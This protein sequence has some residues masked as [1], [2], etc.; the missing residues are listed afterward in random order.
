MNT[1]DISGLKY[2]TNNNSDITVLIGNDNYRNEL[3]EDYII[4]DYITDV[5]KVLHTFARPKMKSRYING[6][7]LIFDGEVIFTVLFLTE[8]ENVKSITLTTPYM[9]T[10]EPKYLSD[11]K[12]TGDSYILSINPIL[13]TVESKLVNPRKLNVKAKL[14]SRVSVSRRENI[15]PTI[16]GLKRPEDELG[17][18]RN[19][20]TVS[21]LHTTQA[22]GDELNISDDIEI[23]A[24][25]PPVKEILF[26]G[27][28]IN[29]NEYRRVGDKIN[30]S[31]EAAVIII[32][33][34]DDEQ[35]Y[36]AV[37]KIPV[38][39]SLDADKLNVECDYF[40]GASIASVKTN[41]ENNNYGE[42]R[43]IEL[44]LTYNIELICVNNED[45]ELTLDAY[46]VDYDCDNIFKDI[47]LYTARHCLNTNFSVNASKE[48]KEIG[49]E[50][51]K[52]IIFTFVTVFINDIK[53]DTVHNKLVVEGNAEISYVVKNENQE[54]S[55]I[56]HNVPIKFE[57]DISVEKEA[58]FEYVYRTAASN[59]RG[60]LDS[61]NIYCD[62][63]VLL[64][65]MLIDYTHENIV[66]KTIFDTAKQVSAE[67]API[68]LYYP[69]PGEKL[70][71]IAK[72]YNTT[73]DAISSANNL[74]SNKIT[75]KNVLII[76]R[77][78]NKAILSKI[79]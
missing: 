16:S 39:D 49:A 25:L 20:K 63:E 57:P 19:A 23:D 40:G 73:C 79:I 1:I 37:K 65:L 69:Q 22:V 59:V 24:S 26:C 47:N 13:E 77:K 31:G 43:I 35:I 17:I 68:V 70:W 46:S 64:N 53:K 41:I 32:Y 75:D 14:C 2:K 45:V 72:N 33:T 4:P 74:K 27:A 7:K 34:S 28:D 54:I 42:N 62:F 76:P 51:V 30:F 5:K 60:R 9:N 44:D 36:V 8:D 29:I 48:R 10:A 38:N 3:S 11:Q 21:S 78:R 56:K 67:R 18:E 6:S 50:N 12:G 66:S 15:S 52:D 71:D 58:E 61:N 55:N